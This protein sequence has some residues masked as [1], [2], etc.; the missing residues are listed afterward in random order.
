M[1]NVLL[2]LDRLGRGGAAQ[3]VIS[4]ALGLDRTKFSPIVCTT[5]AAPTLGQDK[6]LEEAGIQFLQLNR[7]H[8]GN[9]LA[10]S[11]L[12]QVLP[13]TTILHAHETGSNFWGRLWGR[14][15]GVP[16]VITHD[17]T[18][19]NEKGRMK[20]Y[21]D[22]AMSGLSDRIVTV[23]EFDRD[24]SIQHEHLSPSKVQAIYN[25]IDV[26]RFACPLDKKQAREKAGLP[27]NKQLIAVVGRLVPQKNHATLLKAL[28]TLP[29]D[30]RARTHCLFA[31]D[32]YLAEQLRS[33]AQD[34]GLAD[35]VSFLGIRPDVSVILRAVDLMVLP[36]HW[37]C[38]PIVILEALAAECPI[39]AT[40]VGG[41]PEVMNGLGWPIVSQ[42][43]PQALASAIDHVLRMPEEDRQRIAKAGRRT[44]AEKFSQKASV[45]RV[46]SL[47]ESLLASKRPNAVRV[48]END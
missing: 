29:E 48:A 8:R 31:G 45:Q 9:L 39:V 22:R 11:P 26:D 28:A 42:D 10:W 37:E 34:L 44:T 21:V 40:P 36:S 20:H 18:A 25:G 7:R 47:Y 19:A 32:G 41:I 12:W 14:M 16:I 46:Q 6:V 27:H 33:Q 24:L 1:C 38:L 23:S 35:Y 4:T 15:F 2:M 30:F 5:R 3:V 43:D 13:K 17:H